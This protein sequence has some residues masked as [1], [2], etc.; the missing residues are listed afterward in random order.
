MVSAVPDLGKLNSRDPLEGGEDESR[1]RWCVL[2]YG[3]ASSGGGRASSG[4]GA[5]GVP[6]AGNISRSLEIFLTCA[7][8]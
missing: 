3:G 4:G 2:A 8:A 6:A 5:T 7:H 1:G